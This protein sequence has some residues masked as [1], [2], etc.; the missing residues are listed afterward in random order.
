MFGK[1]CNLCGFIDCVYCVS[2]M[3][4]QVKVHHIQHS[5]AN[6]QC[7]RVLFNRNT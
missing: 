2:F 1:L 3:K 5:N 6:P 7:P 4:F